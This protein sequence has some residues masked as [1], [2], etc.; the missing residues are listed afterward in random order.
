MDVGFVNQLHG[1]SSRTW[2]PCKLLP[3]LAAR[4]Q[5]PTTRGVLRV[6]Q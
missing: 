1:R 3:M 2:A 5:I 6:L 4:Q